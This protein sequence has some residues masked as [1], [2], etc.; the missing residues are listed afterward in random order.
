MTKRPSN[1]SDKSSSKSSGGTSAGK[2]NKTVR[3]SKSTAK[4]VTIDLEAETVSEKKAAAASAAKRSSVPKTAT[5]ARFEP[6]KSVEPESK[7]GQSAKASKEPSPDGSAPKATRPARAATDGPKQ[8]SKTQTASSGRAGRL[9]AAVI[10]GL[11]ALGGAGILQYVGIL[12]SLG[13][14][15]QSYVSDVRWESEKQTLQ[16]QLTA[17]QSSIVEV[18]KTATADTG[19]DMTAINQTI[20]EKLSALEKSISETGVTP[21]AVA[22]VDRS[23]AEIVDRVAALEV[24]QD[25]FSK[26]LSDDGD[27]GDVVNVAQTLAAI[28][29]IRQRLSDIDAVQKDNLATL[30]TLSDQ[31][32]GLE[33]RLVAVDS[34]KGRLDDVAGQIEKATSTSS[35]QS[36]KLAALENRIANGADQKAAL[37]IAAAALKSDIDRGV[38]FSASLDTMVSVA[39]SDQDFAGLRP[40]AETGVATATALAAEFDR[41]TSDAILSTLN[42]AADDSLSS[43]LL[44]GARSL[45][46][47]RP[48]K[49]LEGDTPDALISQIYD[50]LSGGDLAK[51]ASLWDK[52][53]DEG[54]SVSQGWH[55]RL[56][57]RLT[58]DTLIEKTLKSYLL[59]SAG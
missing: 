3:H 58:T 20:D 32:A 40:F 46:K 1:N 14:S 15:S 8:T 4:P 54:K 35:D 41:E 9:V 44:A 6:K 53:P 34:L 30:S 39:G 11:V 27:T 42:K 10:G 59:S 48:I 51:A 29:T 49:P 26:D 55:D 16:E 17:L 7:P 43:Q 50:A 45:V 33:P 25:E 56:V 28:A 22:S 36:A 24:K 31:I 19:P 37:A 5:T 52:L 38:S 12:G 18:Q 23:V 57:A 2:V 21:E 13:Q 47:V